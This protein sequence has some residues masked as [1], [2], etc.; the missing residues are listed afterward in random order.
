MFL[1]GDLYSLLSLLIR[2]HQKNHFKGSLLDKILDKK[3]FRL[4]KGLSHHKQIVYTYR[5]MLKHD[6]DTNPLDWLYKNI[7]YVV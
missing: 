5:K 4:P 1:K 2:D 6:K 3:S 7:S